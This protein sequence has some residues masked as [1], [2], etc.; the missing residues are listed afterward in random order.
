MVI[1]KI[2][3][4]DWYGEFKYLNAGT[5]FGLTDTLKEFYEL[6]VQKMRE[7]NDGS[8]SEQY[9]VRHVFADTQDW[10]GIDY[11]ANIMQTFGKTE[12]IYIN[13]NGEK[14]LDELATQAIHDG[15]A[16]AKVV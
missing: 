16:I 11:N 4:R 12:I 13:K 6:V 15:K 10:V 5:A 1:D 9:Y 3:R 2:E 8:T 7:L 14:I